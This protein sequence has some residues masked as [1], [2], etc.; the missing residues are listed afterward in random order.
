M[1]YTETSD[2]LVFDSR[3]GTT[4][5][6][7]NITY[8]APVQIGDLVWNDQDAD[9]VQDAGEPGLSGVTVGLYTSGGTLVSSMITD[10][11]GQYGFIGLTSGS[12]YYVQFTLPSN[13]IFSPK[14]AGGAA[15]P[16]GSGTDS[17]A[18]TAT[19]RTD[20]FTWGGT[21]TAAIDAGMHQSYIGD[22]FW[23]DA[24]GDGIQDASEAPYDSPA[25][26]IGLYSGGTC[27]GTA[28][29]TT[30]SDATGFYRFNMTTRATGTYWVKF[31]APATYNFT[32]KDQGANDAIDSDADSAG[33][34]GA[35]AWT[36]D[37]APN[38]TV[39][40]GLSQSL[41][42]D[43]VWYDANGDG[44]Q[45]AGETTGPTGATVELHGVGVYATCGTVDDTVTST[46]T[47]GA[48]A[49]YSFA[50]PANGTYCIK[51][52][53]PTGYSFS[54][55]YTGGAT[56]PTG[57]GTDSDASQATDY[58]DTFA[59]TQGGTSITSIDAG[60]TTS[61]IGN[62][63][64]LDANADGA[65][66]AGESGL[67][68]VIVRLY[69]SA[70]APVDATFTDTSGNYTLSGPASGQYYLLFELPPGYTYSP[71]YTGGATT[72]TGADTDSD[73]NMANGRTDN[74]TWTAG[75]TTASIDAGMWAVVCTTVSF[76]QGTG[77]YPSAAIPT[78]GRRT[79]PRI[80]ELTLRSMWTAMKRP[81]P[82]T[83]SPACSTGT[84]RPSRPARRSSLL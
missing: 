43:R 68:G 14:Y 18:D 74:F 45:D 63:V 72:P 32:A 13:Y 50:N 78:S 29:A 64:W 20:T 24:D 62:R 35:I 81:A 4:P 57:S 17:D 59:W 6:K 30:D 61:S 52:V 16:T 73:V 67:A 48:T 51:F 33:C 27:A 42:G 5:P 41:I 2:N 47:T 36:A 25:T 60:L 82:V 1:H 40:A 77:G 76:Q 26:T 66:D 80:T 7:L 79:Y 56:T 37:Q 23:Y 71:K 75:G 10:A 54:P 34:S 21:A 65:Q 31:T 19:G 12:S 53:A 11:L 28:L 83:T 39:D 69:T 46:A 49:S 8:C 84:S 15:T 22:Y 44:I 38:V 9:G 70:G 55:K 3:N 58:T